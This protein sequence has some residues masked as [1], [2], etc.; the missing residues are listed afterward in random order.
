MIVISGMVGY[1]VLVC[2]CVCVLCM[3][4]CVCS[5]LIIINNNIIYVD[6]PE[7][8]RLTAVFS[9]PLARAHQTGSLFPLSCNGT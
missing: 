4:M 2:V 5:L 6:R 3:C 8:G 9:C 7:K 1:G